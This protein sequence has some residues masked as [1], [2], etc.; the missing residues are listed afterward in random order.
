M[1]DANDDGKGASND[2]PRWR[3]W[4]GSNR[5]I[6]TTLISIGV[7]WVVGWFLIHTEGRGWWVFTAAVLAVVLIVMFVATV[8][9]TR[10]R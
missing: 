2:V 3:R 10:G 1:H 8:R 9:D 7:S 6:A 4:T 5:D